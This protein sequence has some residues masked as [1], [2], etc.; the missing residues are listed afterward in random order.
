MRTEEQC[1]PQERYLFTDEIWSD[2]SIFFWQNRCIERCKNR[3]DKGEEYEKYINWKRKSNEVALFTMY[4][5][6]DFKIPKQF[7]CIFDLRNP[8][9]FISTQMTLT[10]SIWEAWF[11]MDLIDHGHKHLCIFEFEEE[12]PAILDKLHILKSNFS[13]VP[14]ETSR[15]GICQMKDFEEIKYER[16]LINSEQY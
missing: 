13:N 6:A 7:D 3:D 5:Y 15:L 16:E 12:I 1:E 8:S 4:A 14:K 9:N 10:Q 11:P 2:E